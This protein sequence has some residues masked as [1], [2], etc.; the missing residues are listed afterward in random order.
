[1]A[2]PEHHLKQVER[3]RRV[4]AKVP[5]RGLHRLAR[6]DRSGEVHHCLDRKAA[7]NAVE[8]LLVRN[9]PLDELRFNGDRGTIAV[10]EIVISDD[11]VSGADEL[12]C[13]NTTDV[14]CTAG[15]EY[16]QVWVLGLPIE[17]SQRL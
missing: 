17:V 10:R 7:E 3:V 5:L 14:S 1:D 16:S 2:L 4:V 9:V 12:L 6:L 8:L 11:F 13:D 15:Y